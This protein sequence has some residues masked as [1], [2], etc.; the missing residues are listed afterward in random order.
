MNILI[1]GGTGFIGSRLAIKCIERGDNVRVFSKAN[2]PAE[3]YNEKII[4]D[5]GVE[6]IMGSMSDRD[7]LAKITEGIDVIVHLAAAQHEANIQDQIFRDV[8]VEGTRNLLDA[9]VK[10]GV[11]RF[12]HGSTIGVYG[13]LDGVINEESPCNP[14][15]IYGVTKLEGEKVVLSYKE[16]IPVVIIR[17]SETYGPGDRRLLKLFKIIKKKI[18]FM[19]GSGKN[20][21]QL[22]YIDD[23][24]EG[25]FVA[26]EKE[27]AVGNI[28]LLAGEKPITTNEMVTTIASAL[29]TK[30]P[31]FRAPL[32]LF[33]ILAVIMETV[34]KPLGIQPPL[35]RRRMDFF[36]KSFSFSPKH[37]IEIL[38]FK[39]KTGFH[40][41]VLV[42][43][44]WYTEMGML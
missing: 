29:K 34:L 17:I 18:F 26:A 27:E 35:H 30:L 41:G 33:M 19:I 2:N 3:E 1:T 39:A 40:E 4:Q 31:G 25:F 42:T 11:K 13:I 5:S 43:A 32:F 10:S 36:K 28:F 6:V 44:R 12:V 8:N 9:A 21:H 15:N 14:V 7:A 24:I 22:I 23:L 16:K 37:S 20:L 38:G